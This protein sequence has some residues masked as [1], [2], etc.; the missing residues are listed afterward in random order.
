MLPCNHSRCTHTLVSKHFTFSLLGLLL[1]I[2]AAWILIAG[3]PLERINHVCAPI[4]WTGK[5]FTAVADIASDRAAQSVWHGTANTF[6]GCRFV[7]FRTFYADEYARAQAAEAARKA[8]AEKDKRGA[9]TPAAAT[10]G[11]P[12]AGHAQ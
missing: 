12:A 4:A 10:S 3:S 8:E 6:Q 5:A 1:L 11:Q 9:K 2:F 7:M